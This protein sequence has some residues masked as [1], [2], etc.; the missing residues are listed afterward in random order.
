MWERPLTLTFH[1]L[2]ETTCLVF[3][4]P[5]SS[6]SVAEILSVLFFNQMRY[7]IESP[8]A[9]NADRLVLS[10]GHACPALYAAWSLAG[11]FPESDLLNLRKI[12][13]DLEGHPTPVCYII[14]V[15]T[16]PLLEQTELI[17]FRTRF[18]PLKCA[19]HLQNSPCT[20]TPSSL[21]DDTI[22]ISYRVM[23]DYEQIPCNFFDK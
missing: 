18:S 21:N 9:P 4:H 6:S 19:M 5:T 22:A 8:K 11:L 23:R 16:H 17:I 14:S 20:M 3:R 13:S 2:L 1:A 15:N 10:K 12:D 7:S